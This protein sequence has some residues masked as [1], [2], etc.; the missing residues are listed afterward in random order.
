MKYNL[1][2]CILGLAAMSDGEWQEKPTFEDRRT[3]QHQ[4]QRWFAKRWSARHA[5]LDAA[6]IRRIFY[7]I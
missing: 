7:W 5:S 3:A 1:N 2:F 4:E 6:P